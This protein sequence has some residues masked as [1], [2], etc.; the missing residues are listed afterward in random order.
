MD[1]MNHRDRPG[2]SR[3]PETTFSSCRRWVPSGRRY[4]S[5]ALCIGN[6]DT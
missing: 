4:D 3:V 5:A 2:Y 6:H 1:T